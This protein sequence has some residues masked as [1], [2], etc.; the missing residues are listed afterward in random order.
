[1]GKGQYLAVVVLFH[2]PPY[3]CSLY[4][5]LKISLGQMQLTGFHVLPDSADT[6]GEVKIK[7]LLIPYMVNNTSAKII[8]VV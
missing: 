4:N 5:T 3:F 2:I 7:H 6:L 1:M 8:K